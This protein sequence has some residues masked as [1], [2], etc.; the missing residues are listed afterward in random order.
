MSLWA[1]RLSLGSHGC[2][3]MI[4]GQLKICVTHV[5]HRVLWGFKMVFEYRFL[6][7]FIKTFRDNL[8]T[9]LINHKYKTRSHSQNVLNTHK[10]KTTKGQ[11]SM[12]RTGVC[13][14]N[15]YFKNS[16]FQSLTPSYFRGRVAAGI[17]GLRVIAC[18]R[19]AL[20]LSS[21]IHLF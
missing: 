21:S 2:L 11:R 7:Y 8:D 20:F 10:I 14:F 15:K 1:L 16:D 12:L 19:V 9:L 4:V 17:V 3:V 18:F 13:F 6:I 5:S